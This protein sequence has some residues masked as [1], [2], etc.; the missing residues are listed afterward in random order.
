MKN[1]RSFLLALA[2]ARAHAQPLTFPNYLYRLNYNE[3]IIQM[4]DEEG[5][6]TLDGDGN[7][8]FQDF[9]IAEAKLYGGGSCI[10]PEPGANAIQIQQLPPGVIFAAETYG[11]LMYPGSSA[12]NAE[13]GPEAE[14]QEIAISLNQGKYGWRQ[15]VYDAF[16]WPVSF[17]LFQEELINLGPPGS[18]TS[19]P[20]SA[21]GADTS[22]ASRPR[23]TVI[24][25][26]SFALPQWE[27]DP[28]SDIAREYA[29]R[30]WRLYVPEGRIDRLQTPARGGGQDSRAY[31]DLY[32]P[33]YTPDTVNA[34]PA[35]LFRPI[36]VISRFADDL[37]L[38]ELDLE[39][40]DPQDVD[41][42]AGAFMGPPITNTAPLRYNWPDQDLITGLSRLSGFEVPADNTDPQNPSVGYYSPQGHTLAEALAIAPILQEAVSIWLETQD[43]S[44]MTD[45]GVETPAQKAAERWLYQQED[46]WKSPAE[47]AEDQ[48]NVATEINEADLN[49]LDFQELP[50]RRERPQE[51]LI[52][53]ESFEAE[54]QPLSELGISQTRP[55]LNA[56]QPLSQAGV[57][58]GGV[59]GQLEGEQA[60]FIE[61]INNDLDRPATEITEQV[62]LVQSQALPGTGLD[63]TVIEQLNVQ[64]MADPELSRDLGQPANPMFQSANPNAGVGTNLGLDRL[65]IN[66][67]TGL[68]RVLGPAD[69]PSIQAFNN[70]WVARRGR[71]VNDLST[72]RANSRSG[73]PT[74]RGRRRSPGPG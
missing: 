40:L 36:N 61:D 38:G 73:D 16:P 25:D 70:F 49:Q 22:I 34:P 46:I 66:P 44:V 64:S 14:K 53:A 41:N 51:A 35:Q 10:A 12:C 50:I 55:Q 8:M 17:R 68:P 65:G 5:D 72:S 9:L 47:S 69:L 2:V 59:Q 19:L 63:N 20:F 3:P 71:Q 48:L 15:S 27:I 43:Y 18:G 1:L 56:D 33:V 32:Y 4:Y 67:E 42:F 23:P 31:R 11:W 26:F 52:N 37:R 7:P 74:G 39:T 58:V 29:R 45:L 13:K 57:S 21:V 54:G 6:P 28:N 24:E 30:D 62:N 60:G